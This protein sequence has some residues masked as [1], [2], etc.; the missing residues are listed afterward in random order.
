PAFQL[1]DEGGRPV[2]VE[3]TA[4]VPRTGATSVLASRVDPAFAHV[5]EVDSRFGSHSRQLTLSV[6]GLAPPSIFFNLSYTLASARDQSSFSGGGG[7][8]GGF[9]GGSALSG[10]TSPTTAGDPTVR[11]WSRSDFDRRHT[12]VGSLTWPARSWLDLTGIGRVSSGAPYT[13]RV[14]GDVNGD[15]A[16]NDRAFVFD[17][18]AT[19]DTALGNGM[20]RL[21]DGASPRVRECLERQSGRVAARN[22]CAGAWYPTLDLQANLRPNLG[23][24]IGRRLMVSL[25]TVNLL[26]GIDQLLHGDGERRGWGQPARTDATLLYVRGFDPARRSYVY[27]VN[28]RFGDS[29]VARTAYFIPFQLAVQAR[30]QVGPDRQREMMQQMVRALRDTAARGRGP[31]GGLNLRA[32]VERAVPNPAAAVLAR[33]DTLQL[34]AAQVARLET[35][36]DSL[37]ARADSLIETVARQAERAADPASLMNE[38]R[39]RLEQARGEHQ[40][41]L[42]EVQA[43]LTPEQWARVPNAVK[44]PPAFG[45]PGG[46]GPRGQRGA[47]PPGE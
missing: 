36:R 22:S 32:M 33:R 44:N 31:G 46:Q 29:R 6:A 3:P 42:G 8:M 39:P 18:A 38:L 35:L 24:R 17:P 2:F 7:G 45:L 40:R 1:A 28:E 23:G 16:R 27:Q 15:G 5:F 9:G 43:V 21:L 20:R 47:R 11:E 41:A 26:G 37:Q 25:S 4:I 13:P 34:S 30:L 12:L 10:F 19:T 14:G